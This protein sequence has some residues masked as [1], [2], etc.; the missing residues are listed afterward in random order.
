MT[1][2][3][4]ALTVLLALAV[5][6]SGVITAWAHGQPPVAGAAPI[7]HG[8][9]VETVVIGADGQPVSDLKLCPDYNKAFAATGDV[10]A[11]VPLPRPERVGFTAWRDHA[12]EHGLGPRAVLNGARAPPLSR[13]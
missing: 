9:Y 5:M 2:L 1:R 7:C 13:L 11:P 3:R 10:D 12:Q 8:A 4:S 6:A